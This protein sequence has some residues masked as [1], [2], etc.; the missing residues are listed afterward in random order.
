M[1]KS[2]DLYRDSYGIFRVPE[3]T[4]TKSRKP[5]PRVVTA[6]PQ[7]VRR[8]ESY[9]PPLPYL[10]APGSY[11]TFKRLDLHRDTGELIG[12]YDLF[13][14]EIGTTYWVT[15]T[16]ICVYR[17]KWECIRAYPPRVVRER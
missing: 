16:L 5:A 10:A 3:E 1:T 7:E 8:F 9:K 17:R 15:Q 14:R 4:R 13:F 11:S 2:I 12:Y 6:T